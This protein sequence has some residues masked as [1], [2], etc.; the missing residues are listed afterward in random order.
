MK[1]YHLP[2]V[3]VALIDDQDVI[4][5]EAYGLEN[6]E[7]EIPA[8]PDTIYKMYSVAKVFTAIEMMRLVE[9]GLIDL[10]APITDYLPDFS[11]QSRF[12]NSDP[13]TVRAVLAHHAGLPRNGCYN[14]DWYGGA[15]YY[16]R[17]RC[18]V[19]ELSDDVPRWL[20]L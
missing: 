4:W 12:P 9:E 13:I 3:A 11:I 1:Q 19:G 8:T 5:Q 10:D 2:S 17:T 14:V 20:P 6:I 15:R 7:E 18:I 16:G